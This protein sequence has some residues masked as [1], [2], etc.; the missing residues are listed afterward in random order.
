MVNGAPAEHAF[1]EF[2]ACKGHLSPDTID[3]RLPDYSRRVGLA[4][5]SRFERFQGSKYLKSLEPTPEGRHYSGLGDAG[6]PAVIFGGGWAGSSSFSLFS[7]RLSSGSGSVYRVSTSSRPSVVGRCTSII[8]TAASF[9]TGQIYAI[10]L[11]NSAGNDAN[12]PVNIV[13]ATTST[14]NGPGHHG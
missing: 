14:G 4:E 13:F 8:C 3:V 6:P 9:N 10:F 5:L 7:K 11:H 2:I 12:T 1:P